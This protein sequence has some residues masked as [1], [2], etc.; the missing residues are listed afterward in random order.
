[1]DGC[2][3]CECGV[4]EACAGFIYPWW[5]VVLGAIILA[6]VGYG[7]WRVVRKKKL[8]NR[9][10]IV[11]CTVLLVSVLATGAKLVGDEM[12]SSKEIDSVYR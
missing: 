5:W 2:T 11:L 10:M 9:L 8:F 6:C 1:M 4:Q 12:A 3:P 7:I